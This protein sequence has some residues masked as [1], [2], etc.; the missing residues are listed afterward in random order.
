MKEHVAAFAEA[1]RLEEQWKQKRIEAG[2]AIAEALG[3]PDE[4]S[5]THKVD[6]L[7]VKVTVKQP[8]NRRVDWTAFDAVAAAHP[9]EHLPVVHKREL[10]TKGLKWIRDNQP[11]LYAELA[12]AITATPGRV[13]IEIKEAK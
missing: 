2:N 11:Q 9:G 7:G 8:V 12:R 5:K 13:Q 3:T 4:G 1:K 6:E 10:D